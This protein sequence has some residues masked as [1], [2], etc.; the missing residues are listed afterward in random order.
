MMHVFFCLKKIY[1][2]RVWLSPKI[3]MVMCVNNKGK[4]HEPVC[5]G[6]TFVQHESHSPL[7][8]K[9]LYT[10][11]LGRIREQEKTIAL[12]GDNVTKCIQEQQRL[13]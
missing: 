12:L 2:K 1:E 10:Q 6:D 9:A 3:V 11:N 13:V 8:Y 4:S 5:F 7:D